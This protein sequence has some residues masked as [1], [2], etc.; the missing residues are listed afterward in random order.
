MIQK[1]LKPPFLVM[2]LLKKVSLFGNGRS[3]GKGGLFYVEICAMI[4][5]IDKTR[6][7]GARNY[8]L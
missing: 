6:C 5:L 2:S 7:R 4:G 8:G 3:A 1:T